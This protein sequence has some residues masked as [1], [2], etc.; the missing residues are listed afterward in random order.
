[1]FPVYLLQFQHR[2]EPVFKRTFRGV[3]PFLVFQDR[4]R[5][6]TSGFTWKG[7]KRFVVLSDGSYQ[8]TPGI[9]NEWSLNA[10][11]KDLTTV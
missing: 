10:K 11:G 2:R 4:S 7:S 3:M 8:P 5:S 6:S 1:M 9:N